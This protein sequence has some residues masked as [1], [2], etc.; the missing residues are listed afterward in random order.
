MKRTK[1]TPAMEEQVAPRTY[2]EVSD[3]IQD[4]LAYSLKI[5]QENVEKF[6]AE[7]VKDPDYR[8]EWGEQIGR[9][10]AEL[11]FRRRIACQ[12]DSGL[13]LAEAMESLA[14]ELRTA[15]LTNR[16]RAN[17]TSAFHNAQQGARADAARYLLEMLTIRIN[18]LKKVSPPPA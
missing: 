11:E 10:A 6:A 13:G 15:L 14:G 5:L 1:K 16:F 7:F 3:F 12:M 2:Q 4:D 18:E 9:D 17:S 8:M